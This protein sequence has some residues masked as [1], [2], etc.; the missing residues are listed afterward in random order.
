MTKELL[1]EYIDYTEKILY[2]K[3]PDNRGEA[4]YGFR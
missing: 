2:N 4:S 1:T 3:S